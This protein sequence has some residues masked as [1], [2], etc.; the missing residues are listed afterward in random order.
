MIFLISFYLI[1]LNCLNDVFGMIYKI[2]ENVQW[3][4]NFIAAKNT[5]LQVIIIVGRRFLIEYISQSLYRQATKTI[6]TLNTKS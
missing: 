3:N 1:C 6:L 5:N 4:H 2:F